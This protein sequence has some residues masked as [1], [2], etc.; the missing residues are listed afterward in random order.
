[1]LL[2]L[3]SFWKHIIEY[4]HIVSDEQNNTNLL[5]IEWCNNMPETIFTNVSIK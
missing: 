3:L 5:E 2:L 1:M 4:I